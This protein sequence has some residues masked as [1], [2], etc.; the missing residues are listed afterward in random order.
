M[1]LPCRE[2]KVDSYLSFRRRP[3]SR[4]FI[5]TVTVDTNSQTVI[6][7]H[8]AS[9]LLPITLALDTGL[10]RCDSEMYS[11]LIGSQTGLVIC[12]RFEK[13]GGGALAV[14]TAQAGI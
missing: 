12:H 6:E 13:H 8:K 2:Q 10:R 9:R 5:K 4:G 14:I 7:V 11:Y 1:F 3:G